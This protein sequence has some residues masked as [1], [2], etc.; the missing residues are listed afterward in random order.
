MEYKILATLEL[1]HEYFDSFDTA[2][3]NIVI[4]D[5][6][7]KIFRNYRI[8]IKKRNK[9]FI[10]ITESKNNNL[11][12]PIHKISFQLYISD[13]KNTFLNYTNLPFLNPAKGIY[14][15]AN[16]PN[17]AYSINNNSCTSANYLNI[18]NQ[19]ISVN[20]ISKQHV[21][22]T[23]IENNAIDC[24]INEN[25][26]ELIIFPP[27][28]IANPIFIN[29]NQDLV[30]G[31]IKKTSLNT[32]YFAQLH[33]GFENI[34]NIANYKPQ[35]LSLSFIERKLFWRY[36]II[37]RNRE[38]KQLAIVDNER[39]IQFIESVSNIGEGK[40]SIFTSDAPIACSNASQINIDLIESDVNGDNILI[41][42][43]PIPPINNMNTYNDQDIN[44][45]VI[46]KFVYI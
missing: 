35:K 43:L 21:H 13:T 26:S 33:I 23:D 31:Y 46:E 30:G 39:K 10:F 5:E 45:F 15:F 11:L 42:K 38:Y 41:S 12:I 22:L 32:K 20:N 14:Y 1:N 24:T 4:P 44:T 6:T 37:H 25:N 36:K 29:N 16:T 2:G 3:L 8:Q 19:H 27:D 17:N 28:T 40:T 34:N 7:S 9:Q 18:Y